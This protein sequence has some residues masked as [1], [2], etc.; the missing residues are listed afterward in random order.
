MIAPCVGC[1]DTVANGMTRLLRVTAL[2]RD[3]LLDRH[4]QFPDLRQQ[5]LRRP[6]HRPRA[7]HPAGSGRREGRCGVVDEI[8][9]VTLVG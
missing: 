5:P 1:T 4:A 3:D 8:L 7:V 2:L 6:A 9:G